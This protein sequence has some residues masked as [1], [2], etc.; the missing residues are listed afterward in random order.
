MG[1][2]ESHFRGEEN[3]IES[4]NFKS[5]HRGVWAERLKDG[6]ELPIGGLLF[7]NDLTTKL[8]LDF[9]F[10]ETS[11][12]TEENI[13][14]AYEKSKG[15]IVDWLK[16]CGSGVD[17]YIYFVCFNAQKKVDDLLKTNTKEGVSIDRRM[18]FGGDK[19]PKLSELVGKTE[20]AERAALGQFLLQ[21]A[22]LKSV[23]MS[24]V[25][26]D[27]AKD[28]DEYA[29]AH[30]FIVVEQVDRTD[31][32]FIFDIARPHQG[33]NNEKIARVLKTEAPLTYDLFKGEEELLV[34]ADDVLQQSKLWFG[35]GEPVNGLHKIIEK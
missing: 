31:E 14:K 28:Q 25:S 21:K 29:I 20:C 9:G 2:N 6:Q 33:N 30:S 7:S 22:G 17:P 35:V 23:Y 12:F 13:H 27:D 1:E 10:F 24:G 32:T 18:A 4:E 8:E 11:G 15:A 3:N 19:I 5:I 16:K 34:A 26:M